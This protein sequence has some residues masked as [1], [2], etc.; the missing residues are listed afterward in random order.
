MNRR[1]AGYMDRGAPLQYGRFLHGRLQA[2]MSQPQLDRPDVRSRCEQV[3][4]KGMSQRANARVLVNR[5]RVLG[6]AK[7]PLHGGARSVP[8]RESQQARPP[9]ETAQVARSDGPTQGRTRDRRRL[10]AAGVSDRHHALPP[11][12]QASAPSRATA[13]PERAQS[14][15]TDRHTNSFR[16]APTGW[17]PAAGAAAARPELTQRNAC[18]IVVCNIAANDL[19][20]RRAETCAPAVTQPRPALPTSPLGVIQFP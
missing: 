19:P 14:P 12:W 3:S 17:R 9:P 8:A 20:G 10:P 2:A 16:C 18:A 4:G 11:P 6:I 13:I 5:S 1:G 7:C 15:V